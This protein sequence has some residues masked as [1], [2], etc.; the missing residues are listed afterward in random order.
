MDFGD[1]VCVVLKD[2]RSFEGML[3]PSSEKSVVS[4]KLTSG[5]N[6]GFKESEVK[7]K[8]V[9][10]KSKVVKKKV[11]KESSSK[12]EAITIL[13]TGGTIASSVDY[14]TGSVEALFSPDELVKMFPELKKI[15]SINS[16][17]VRNMWSHDLRFSHVNLL[18]KE[19]EKEVKS[20][21]KGVIVTSGTDTLHYLSA[22]LAFALEHVPIPVLVVGAQ[23]SSDRGSSDAE[24]NFLNAAYFIS[25]SRFVGVAVCMYNSSNGGECVI[26]PA[27]K[28]RKLHTS[29]RDAFQVVNGE[30]L[31]LVHYREKKIR[32]FV[33]F[34]SVKEDLKV[35]LFNERLKIGMLKT[36]MQMWPEE[37]KAYE[38]FDGL[39]LEGSGLGHT[40]GYE[41]D[42]DTKVH[43]KIFPVVKKLVKNGTLV[44]MSSQ[45]LFGRVN[46]NVYS[47][48][49][50]IQ[51][52][53]VLGNYS[54]MTPE[55]SFIKLAWLLSNHNDRV[56]ELFM[57]NLRG[58]LS[59]RTKF[60]EEF[61]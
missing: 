5:Y 46:M 38:G 18:A 53:G 3:M 28:V 57:E 7:S 40:P 36:H 14:R 2:G 13:H 24:D 16:R 6:V 29:R 61:V 39:V 26:L 52:L 17:L 54:D 48:G 58:E 20:G 22:A 19:V 45:C 35:K 47:K 32:E 42:R 44:V 11:K 41:L 33:S 23:R 12:K 43:T 60:E 8:K 4:L 50:D 51:A 34:P 56:E 55:T 25:E 30:K 10:K 49:R 21:V 59:E 15:G 37:F 9:L 1:T 27:C 31:A